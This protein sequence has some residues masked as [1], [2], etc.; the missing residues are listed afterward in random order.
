MESLKRTLRF[1]NIDMKSSVIIFWIVMILV[2]IASYLF[3]IGSIFNIDTQ[4]FTF[5]LHI[6]NSEMLEVSSIAG[7]NVVPI[8]IFYTVY[9]Y[10]TYYEDLPIAIGFSGTRRNFFLSNIINN[11]MVSLIF[12]FVQT[13]L[14]KIDF[15][16]IES[17]GLVPYTDFAVF[18]S[19]VDNVMIIFLSIFIISICFLGFM[20]LLASAN[21]KLGYKM[22]I[23]LAVIFVIIMPF[24]GVE[25]FSLLYS[26]LSRRIGL[27]Q[28]TV[29]VLITVITYG[30]NGLFIKEVSIKPKL[31]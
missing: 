21:Y 4:G 26:L 18:N 14:L 2:N 9:I 30:L 6:S 23:I 25:I 17:L 29:L 7:A 20:N 11:I 5:G 31:V 10:T 24:L 19:L 3:N 16:L 28:F 8:L 13:I 1:L 22:W 27:S 15:K 12:A